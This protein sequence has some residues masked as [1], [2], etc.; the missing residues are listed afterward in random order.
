MAL[1]G[2][3][4]TA[5]LADALGDRASVCATPF[6]QFGGRRRFA[7]LIRTVC[8]FGDNLLVRSA[9]E[10]PGHGAV[11]VVDGG[12]HLGCALLGDRLATLGV[13]NGWAGA[14]IFGAVRDSVALAGLDFGVKALGTHPRRSAKTGAGQSGVRVT[15]GGVDFEPGHWLASDDDGVLVAAAP[16]G[17]T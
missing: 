6:R 9:L 14:V 8:C 2:N 12:G 1:A 3:F 17:G 7:G 4:S 13:T 16:P 11:L 10:S 5:D 15:F